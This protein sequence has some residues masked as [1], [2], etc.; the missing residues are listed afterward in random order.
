MKKKTL[1]LI[2]DLTLIACLICLFVFP[3]RYLDQVN[4][5]LTGGAQEALD[6]IK[7]QDHPAAVAVLE[8]LEQYYDQHKEPLM[9]FLNHKDLH[10]L[11]ASLRGSL[12][13][14]RAQDSAQVL[15]ELEAVMVQ[16]HYLSSIERFSI[17]NLL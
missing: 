6:A 17:F 13:L 4:Q 9:L 10:E 5:T 8:R 16:T 7:A 3:S 11:E 14:A 1:D 15:L 2:V 12:E